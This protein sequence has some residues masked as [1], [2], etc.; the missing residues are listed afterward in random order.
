MA[1]EKP[2]IKS[3]GRYVFDIEANGLLEKATIIWCLV[4]KDIDTHEKFVYSDYSKQSF[5]RPLIEGLKKLKAANYVVCHNVFN[6]DLNLVKKLY[7][8]YDFSSA[9][10]IDSLIISQVSHFSRRLGKYFNKHGLEAWGVHFKKYKPEQEVWHKFEESQI[11]RCSEDVEINYLAYKQVVW[12]LKEAKIDPTIIKR[13]MKVGLMTAEQIRNGWLFDKE[14]ARKHVNTLNA[15]LEELRAEIEPNLPPVVKKPPT[16]MTWKELNEFVGGYW[17]KVP[18]DRLDIKGKLVKPIRKPVKVKYLASN[19]NYT[20]AIAKYFDIAPET[21]HNKIKPIEGFFTKVSFEPSN[22]GQHAQVKKFLLTQG[23]KPT[24]WTYEKVDGKIIKDGNNKPIKKSPK[25]TEDSYSSIKG[26]IGKK[27]ATFNTLISRRNTIENQ[28]DPEKG[29][30]N[31]LREDG[32][33]AC[34]AK[35]VGAATARMTHGGIVN[36]PGTKALFGKEMRELFICP[37]DKVIVACDMA[38]AQLRLLAAAMGDPEYIKVVTTGTEEDADGNYIGTDIH[39]VN[40]IA[41]GLI[42]PSWEKG[43]KQWKAGRAKAKTFILN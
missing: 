12:E 34:Y 1:Q 3:K 5:V 11:H 21:A 42:D 25:L 23:W 33:L 4:L 2:Q 27:V 22:M 17:V 19:G 30:L 9:K 7:P 28:K 24:E 36:V 15:K 39:S 14:K 13:E 16:S 20:A 8:E 31:N 6:Y 37:K 35:T 26:E 38:S 32:R 29:W 18:E 40:G 10:I 41:A 43:G